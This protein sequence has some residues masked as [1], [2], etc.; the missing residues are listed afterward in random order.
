MNVP[1][2][3]FQNADSRFPKKR[4]RLNS[5]RVFE[6]QKTEKSKTTVGRFL[7]KKEEAP[8]ITLEEWNELTLPQFH[9]K[10]LLGHILIGFGFETNL[11]S[12]CIR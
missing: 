7:V 6:K 2:H 3:E 11:N 1:F 12:R 8:E 5:E 10:N 4:L 9:N